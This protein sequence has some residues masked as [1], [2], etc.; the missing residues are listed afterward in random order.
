LDNALNI[1]EKYLEALKTIDGWVTVSE[2]AVK[3]GE[4]YPD[5]LEK[6]NEEARNQAND[7]TGLREIAARIGSA[8][9][10]GA[11]TDHI[12]IDASERPRKVRYVTQEE[13]EAN[14]LSE[15]DEDVAPLRRSDIIRLAEQSMS[16]SD[17]YRADEFEGIA[18]QLKRYFGLDF[19]V[20]H[21][22]ALLNPNNP[23]NHH[24]DNFQLILKSH[25]SKKNND[26]W[27]RFALDEQVGYIQSVIETQSIVATRLGIEITP[28]VLGSLLERLRKVY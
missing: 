3:V 4:L 20:D 13:H 7:T 2:W 19:E 5:L 21:A 25:N 10:H 17:K 16:N 27:E 6:A 28:D 26:N 24:P 14:V 12:E 22:R 15:I 1:R 8:I 23:G 9:V 18:K 11:Y